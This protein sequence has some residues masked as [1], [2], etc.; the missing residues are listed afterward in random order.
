MGLL[1]LFFVLMGEPVLKEDLTERKKM[2]TI[3]VT[4]V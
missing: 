4:E 1:R 3:Y 2:N